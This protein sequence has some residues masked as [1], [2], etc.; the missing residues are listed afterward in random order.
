[1]WA[2]KECCYFEPRTG[3]C[4]DDLA[5]YLGDGKESALPTRV[6]WTTWQAAWRSNMQNKCKYKYKYTPK[7][8]RLER[9]F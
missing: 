5:S 1:M 6:V 7:D 3:P 2:V 8:P 4:D 9:P